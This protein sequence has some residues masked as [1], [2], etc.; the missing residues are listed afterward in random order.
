MG[1]LLDAGCGHA[2]LEGPVDI[3][4]CLHARQAR[5]LNLA[6]R[7]ALALAP[8]LIGGRLKQRHGQRPAPVHYPGHMF[9]YVGR[10][11]V[12]SELPEGTCDAHIGCGCGIPAQLCPHLRKR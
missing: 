7:D 4:R 12:E 3:L 6:L 2:L 1:E 8:G 11:R 5:I 9:P 10:H